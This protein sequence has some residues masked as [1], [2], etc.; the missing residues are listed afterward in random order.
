MTSVMRVHLPLANAFHKHFAFVTQE[1]DLT[2]VGQVGY[3]ERMIEGSFHKSLMAGI[4]GF[5]SKDARD[6]FIS[7]LNRS[8][9]DEVAFIASINPATGPVA[10]TEGE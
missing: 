9:I 5:R 8:G 3:D 10:N 7:M 1:I 2:K 6:S 4:Y